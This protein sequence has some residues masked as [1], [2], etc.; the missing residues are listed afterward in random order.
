MK[1]PASV[2]F[3][4][5]NLRKTATSNDGQ[6]DAHPVCFDTVNLEIGF[7]ALIEAIA[8]SCHLR[9]PSASYLQ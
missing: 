8:F 2:I 4:I 6:A 5:D 7:A 3:T 9:H 1:S